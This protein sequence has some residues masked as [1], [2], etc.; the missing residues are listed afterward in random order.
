MESLTLIELEEQLKRMR[1][2][3]AEDNTPVRLKVGC[4]YSRLLDVSQTIS[5]GNLGKRVVE[6]AG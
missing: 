6:L 1:E 4:Y 3:N 5:G 2:Q